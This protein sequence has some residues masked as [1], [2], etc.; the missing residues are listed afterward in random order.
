MIYVH[1][2]GPIAAGDTRTAL[3]TQGAIATP[4]TILVP[5]GCTKITQVIAA[6]GDNT[7]AATDGGMN[8]LVTL[9]GTGM[10]DGDQVLVVGASSADFTTAGDT[11]M[12]ARI[13]DRHDVDI[14]VV[15]NGVVNIY[16]EGTLG[17]IVGLPEFGVTLGFA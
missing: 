6:V 15:S 13:F 11:G 8:Y 12:R 1:R 2:E 3:V 9:S 10:T 16:A 5:S 17:V 7:P 14:N 4:G